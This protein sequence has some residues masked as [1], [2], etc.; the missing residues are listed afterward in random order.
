MVI[1]ACVTSGKGRNSNAITCALK[2]QFHAWGVIIELA[3]TEN[4]LI[5]TA[6]QLVLEVTCEVIMMESASS[7]RLI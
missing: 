4:L 5:G 7:D 6:E 3:T 1:A 2:T